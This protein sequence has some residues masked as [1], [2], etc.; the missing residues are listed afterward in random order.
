[1]RQE[2]VAATR[3]G[4]S[5]WSHTHPR[6]YAIVTLSHRE[7]KLGT[8]VDDRDS[9]LI[10]PDDTVSSGVKPQNA[11]FFLSFLPPPRHPLYRPSPGGRTLAR[12]GKSLDG[13]D[14]CRAQA[15]GKAHRVIQDPDQNTRHTFEGRFFRSSSHDALFC[16]E[17]DDPVTFTWIR[18]SF[19]G[20]LAI[21][22]LS[23]LSLNALF[24]SGWTRLE[25]NLIRSVRKG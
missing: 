6:W 22:W 8:R 19:I 20:P 2:K 4:L 21:V 24:A 3:G 1:M 12:K 18:A 16:C 13:R 25:K 11:L 10:A 14:M 5:G 7:R 15:S 17:G 9:S 23:T